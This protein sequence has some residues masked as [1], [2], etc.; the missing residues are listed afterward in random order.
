MPAPDPLLFILPNLNRLQ[1]P[2]AVSGGVAAIY[3]GEPRFTNDVDIVLYLQAGDVP[4]LAAAFPSDQYYCPPEEVIRLELER[5]RRGHFNLIHH[6]S[7][8]KADIYLSGSDPLHE[9]AL[10]RIR[11]SEI[12]GETLA[13]APPEYVIVRKLQYY[14]EGGSTK[15]LRDIQRMLVAMG[16]DWDRSA[17]EGL[18]R[19]HGLEAEWDA[20]KGYTGG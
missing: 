11:K 5:A 2:Y 8:F 12:E 15:H 14:R 19:Q 13:L 18:L 7:G 10:P 16:P 1:I 9:W 4:R 6:Q 20:A 17:A 3:Y